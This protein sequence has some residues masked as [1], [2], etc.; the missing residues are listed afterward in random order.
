MRL[1][2]VTRLMEITCVTSYGTTRAT[3]RAERNARK[4]ALFRSRFAVLNNPW[5]R[6]AKQKGKLSELQKTN[7]R[8]YRAYLL[9]GSTTGNLLEDEAPNCD[10]QERM[11]N[12]ARVTR[13]RWMLTMNRGLAQRS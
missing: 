12:P 11:C 8:R 1:K 6:N 4:K 7:A 13:A 9:K 10:R 2:H 3:A 5:N